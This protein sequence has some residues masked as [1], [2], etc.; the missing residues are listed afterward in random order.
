MYKE[1][2]T[3]NIGVEV[4]DDYRND[5]NDD[6]NKCIFL[7]KII[8]Y[9]FLVILIL[10]IINTYINN[11]IVIY[12]IVFLNIAYVIIS[13]INDIYF[14]NVAE[15]ERRKTNISNSFKVN[16]TSKKTNLYYN[17][18]FEPSI[19][20]MGV[21]SFEST[22][23]T[24]NTLSK[25]ILYNAL[26]T[27]LLGVMW[28]IIIVNVK[29]INIFQITTELFFSAEVLL[30]LIKN[31]YYYFETKKLYDDFY[32]QFITKKYNES[33]DLPIILQYVLEY[34][35]LKSYCHF[36]LSERIFEKYKTKIKEEWTSI[37]KEIK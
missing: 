18:Q 4:M 28:I 23:Y 21:N 8:T 29:N 33:E 35:C 22:L 30:V 9:L 1:N 19:K 37:L 25:M 3:K 7:E 32:Y 6:Y 2:I 16:I 10:S 14:I 11:E 13:F 24:K 31:I 20:K 26:K 12:L 27:F 5:V 17:N 34:E 15:N 36:L